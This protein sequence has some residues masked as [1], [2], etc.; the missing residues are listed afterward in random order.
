MPW[1]PGR[2]IFRFFIGSVR[3][4]NRRLELAGALV[5]EE[6]VGLCAGAH[7]LSFNDT[8]PCEHVARSLS[9]IR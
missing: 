2:R 8:A 6:A 1:G 9:A 3:P 4:P 7:E 5:L